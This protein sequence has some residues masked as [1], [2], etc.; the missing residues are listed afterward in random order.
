VKFHRMARDFSPV[1]AD[2][3]FDKLEDFEKILPYL[4]PKIDGEWSIMLVDLKIVDCRRLL[5]DLQVPEYLE[6]ECHLKQ[7]VLGLLFAEYPKYRSEEK[8][9]WEQY[10]ETVA[11]FPKTI[12]KR[13]SSELF[14]RCHGD[15]GAIREALAELLTMSIDEDVITIRHINAILLAN[16]SV[17]AKDVI[18]TL[19]LKPNVLVPSRGSRLSRYKYNNP[20]ELYTKLEYEIG[21]DAAFYSMRKYLRN[22]YEGK[23]DYLRNKE[24]KEKEVV[25]VLDVYEI[26]HAYL[27]FFMSSPLQ[28]LTCLTILEERTR[29]ASS[30]QTTVLAN[31]S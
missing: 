18:L 30:F 12:E 14:K 17:Y 20:F 11:N 5:D 8:S 16:D 6:I 13:A 19:L 24:T 22:L 21:R 31:F 23:I 25:E 2:Y 15:V 10:L 4:Y 9:K 28:I 3:I 29:D 7:D 27:T 26:A 1:G